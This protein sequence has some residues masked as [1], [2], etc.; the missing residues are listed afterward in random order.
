MSDSNKT[1]G[2]T[3]VEKAEARLAKVKTDLVTK[4]GDKVNPDSLRKETD[5]KYSGKFTVEINTVGLDGKPDG[6]TRRVAT[7]DVFQVSHTDE[8]AKQLR[9]QALRDKRHAKAASKAKATA[10]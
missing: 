2:K 10:V 7:S 4:Y 9:K 8:V 5:G 6:N 1:D 3:E